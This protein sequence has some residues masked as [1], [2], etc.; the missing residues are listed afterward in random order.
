MNNEVTPKDIA[1]NFDAIVIALNTKV[2]TPF[3]PNVS[4]RTMFP[5]SPTNAAQVILKQHS[6]V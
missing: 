4:L 3:L 1:I 5:R 6:L 2:A